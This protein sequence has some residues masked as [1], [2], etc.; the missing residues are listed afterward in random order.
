MAGF[1][2]RVSILWKS[3][4]SNPVASQHKHANARSHQSVE[5]NVSKQWFAITLRLTKDSTIRERFSNLATQH[6]ELHSTSREK[7]KKLNDCVGLTK[8]QF[9]EA[10]CLIRC[11]AQRAR[12][13]QNRNV[14]HERCFGMWCCCN[15]FFAL[16]ERSTRSLQVVIPAKAET[17]T[18]SVEDTA[19]FAVSQSS[20][21]GSPPSRG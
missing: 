9:V 7:W 13:S 12:V 20:R 14:F 1:F 17:Q 15:R 19:P 2:S 4:K 5:K 16:A 3:P 11:G 6:T 21:S 18:P 10:T 8:A